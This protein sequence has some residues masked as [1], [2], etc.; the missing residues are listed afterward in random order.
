[1]NPST[2]VLASEVVISCTSW[3]N[4]QSPVN[5]S[6][7]SETAKDTG[8]HVDPRNLCDP[9]D[10][11]VLSGSIP[12]GGGGIAQDDRSQ[13]RPSQGALPNYRLALCLIGVNNGEHESKHETE[14]P[15]R[16]RCR[17][18]HAVGR[19]K[20]QAPG[21]GLLH[22]R[23]EPGYRHGDEAMRPEGGTPPQGTDHRI[24]AGQG[25]GQGPVIHGQVGG[26]RGKVLMADRELLGA[27][28]QGSDLM[29]LLERLRNHMPPS[30]S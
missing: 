24:M 12:A 14:R 16:S 3:G 15:G 25:L 18:A 8:R 26:D 9:R 11:E 30:S 4:D 6:R 23:D 22:G 29:P 27:P 2:W 19:K 5:G 21:A 17:S 20:N 28:S 10:G 7:I 13:N 1:M